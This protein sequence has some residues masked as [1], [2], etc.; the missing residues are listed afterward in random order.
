MKNLKIALSAA[1]GSAAAS[2]GLASLVTIPGG[3]QPGRLPLR[4]VL[5]RLQAKLP[6]PWP[7]EGSSQWVPYR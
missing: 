6:A 5:G 3:D 2:V 7:A 4:L 1:A